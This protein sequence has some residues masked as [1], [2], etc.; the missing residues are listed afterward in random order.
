VWSASRRLLASVL[1]VGAAATSS[2]RAAEPV[3]YRFTFPELQ[4]RWMQV[5]VSFPELGSDALELRMSRS[6]PGRYAL[7]D[8]AKNVYDVRA[9]DS[10]GRPIDTRR[11]D[12][13]GWTVAGHG[14]AVTVR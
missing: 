12:P 8:F 4:H 10:E 2:Y 5:E 1:L 11:P 13:H 9:F 7:H 6:S 14:G 3:R